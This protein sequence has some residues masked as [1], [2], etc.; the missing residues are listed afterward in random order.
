MAAR[1]AKTPAKTREKAAKKTHWYSTWDD[2]L[3]NFF[4]PRVPFSSNP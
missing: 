2:P 4:P 1:K 3:S